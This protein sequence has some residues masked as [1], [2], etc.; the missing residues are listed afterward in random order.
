MFSLG[1][2]KD[3]HMWVEVGL[4][5]TRRTSILQKKMCIWRTQQSRKRK[6]KAGDQDGTPDGCSLCTRLDIYHRKR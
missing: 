2:G 3:E 1:W 4:W 5:L 6:K